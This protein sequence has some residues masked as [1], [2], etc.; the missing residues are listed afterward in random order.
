MALRL[1]NSAHF[2]R[3][4]SEFLSKLAKLLGVHFGFVKQKLL[5]P[6]N[7]DLQAPYINIHSDFTIR[8]QRVTR[9]ILT[10][11]LDSISYSLYY[12]RNLLKR[13]LECV[14]NDFGLGYDGFPK[15]NILPLTQETQT[16]IQLM[17]Q[18]FKG[19]LINYVISLYN[20]SEV[21]S[22]LNLNST[23]E[24]TAL[25][26]KVQISV[27]ILWEL[28]VSMFK[29]LKLKTEQMFKKFPLCKCTMKFLLSCFNTIHRRTVKQV[30]I[31]FTYSVM[32]APNLG[33]RDPAH[34]RNMID[35]IIANNYITDYVDEY[36]MSDLHMSIHRLYFLQ[37][38]KSLRHNFYNLFQH[39]AKRLQL[40]TKSRDWKYI[41]GEIR[42]KRYLIPF[43]PPRPP[44][45][46]PW[47]KPIK[48]A[49]ANPMT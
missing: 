49:S 36:F 40:F 32:F 21:Y 19:S 15:F 23:L 48:T 25:Q 18:V 30:Y 3:L 7:Y 47:V 39:L 4:K 35:V 24:E 28:V 2:P 20:N 31:L 9:E 12:D 38:V 11:F 37:I 46:E 43:P 13:L 44:T 14:N 8:A 29:T 45:P 5:Q 6:S 17:F 22:A 16:E 41:A 1:N 26:L 34:F 27:D 10:M 42:T 33:Y